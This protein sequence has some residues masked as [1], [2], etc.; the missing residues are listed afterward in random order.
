MK[1]RPL[2]APRRDGEVLIEPARESVGDVLAENIRL[3]ET[4]QCDVQGRPLRELAA[5][6][7]RQL[8]ADARR[9]TGQYRDLEGTAAAGSDRVFLAGHQPELFHPG[10]WFKNFLLGEIARD[11]SAVAINLQI[12][13]DTMK[14]A[15]IAVPGGSIE[16]PTTHFV[17][18]DHDG[19][20]IPFE[21]RQV[22]DREAFRTFGRRATEILRPLV[23]NPMLTDLWPRAEKCLDATENL[24]RSLAQS[25]HEIEGE[26]GLATLEI[27]QSWVCRFEA[28]HWFTAHLLAQLP[29]LWEAY[30]GALVDYRR[31]NRVRSR[32]HPAPDLACDGD[33]LEAP[34]WIWSREDPRRRGLFVRSCGDQLELTDRRHTTLTLPLTSDGDGRRAAEQLADVSD[35]GIRLR[36]RATI[37]TLFARLF[38]GD[39]F[40]HGIGGGKYDE[41]TD[42]LIHRFFG[43]EPPDLVIASATMHLPVP[44]AR[45]TAA[46]VG[47][48]K[49]L[50]RDLEY[51]AECHLDVAH[52]T[53]VDRA[54]ARKWIDAKQQWLTRPRTFEN[55]RSRHAGIARANRELQPLV[56]DLRR[57]TFA[58][59]DRARA[60]ERAHG[61]LSSREYAFCLYPE[62]N[63]RK[64]MLST[65]AD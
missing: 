57:R 20:E 51:H 40:V 9:F 33:W 62:A 60:A 13:S 34:F 64:R 24:G 2:R 1:S 47:R 56:E 58:E 45:D 10:V 3:R 31:A 65:P 39:L 11:H 48:L 12:D 59:L 18:F 4:A 27:P 15:G 5:S 43:L 16:R 54:S 61:V 49:R 30:N 38:L 26:W 63:L 17:P 41:V 8:V 32:S 29:R 28:F 19:P 35:R 46:E 53:S 23:P 25:R 6:A 37:T 21:E 7:R 44:H 14:R 36:T 52:L 42:V 50:L 22:I 55:A